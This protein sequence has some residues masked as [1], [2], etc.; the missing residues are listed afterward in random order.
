VA[1]V[2]EPRAPIKTAGRDAP[3]L[4]ATVVEPRETTR[5]QSGLVFQC[6]SD[7]SGD[8]EIASV[9]SGENAQARTQWVCPSNTVRQVP[10]ATSQSRSVLSRDAESASAPSGEIYQDGI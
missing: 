9:P 6:R 8:V 4:V 3:G 1:T 10:E 7:P 5:W 2:V